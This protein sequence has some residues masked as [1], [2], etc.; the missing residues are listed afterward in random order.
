MTA[1]QIA[2]MLHLDDP[3]IFP[4]GKKDL[5]TYPINKMVDSSL[6]DDALIDRGKEPEDDDFD[7]PDGD[8]FDKIA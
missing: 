5:G 4:K 3:K 7:Y 8:D 1:E 2:H 6:G